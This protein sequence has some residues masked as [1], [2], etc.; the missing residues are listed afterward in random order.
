MHV[1]LVNGS[2]HK[3]GCTYTALSEVAKTLEQEGIETEIFHIGDTPVRGC[4]ACHAC[5][6]L[7][8][9]V[10][11]DDCANTLAMMYLLLDCTSLPNHR[12]NLI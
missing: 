8:R 10:F 12:R 3:T 11:D 4:N 7:R 1:L 9:C 6:K 5:G 2:P